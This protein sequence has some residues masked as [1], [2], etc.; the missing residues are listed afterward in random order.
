MN[1]LEVITQS[2]IEGEKDKVE[3]LTR[4][5]LDD[6]ISVEQIL[7]E[8]LT[9][10]MN[11]VGERF[12]QADMFIPEVLLAAKAMKAGTDILAPLL[13]GTRF[14]NSAKVVLGTVKGDIHDLGKN[15]VGI[16]LSGAGFEVIDLGVNVPPQKFIEAAAEKEAQLVGLSALLTVTMPAMKDAIEELRK[17]GLETQV[18]TMIGGAPVTR[19]YADEIG[20]DGYAKDAP[21]AVAKAKELLKLE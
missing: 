20:A 6:G 9:G 17:A 19:Q 10:G 2:L 1:R 13:L 21:S 18:K 4:L 11:I 3:E 5:A 7:N 15:L 16:M 12:K 8:G 14:Q